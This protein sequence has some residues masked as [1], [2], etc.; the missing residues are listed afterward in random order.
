MSENKIVKIESTSLPVIEHLNQRVVTLAMVDEVHQRPSGTAGR[1]FRANRERFIESEDYFE[2]SE[3]ND[4]IRRYEWKTGQGGKIILLTESGYLM[5]VKSFTDD[6]AWQVQRAL[7]KSYFRV[8]SPAP[9]PELSELARAVQAL[10]KKITALAALP[11]VSSTTLAS[12]GFLPREWVARIS[13]SSGRLARAKYPADEKEQRRERQRLQMS[14]RRLC[15]P[16]GRGAS[17]A[18]CPASALPIVAGR[19]AE[20]DDETHRLE[21]RLLRSTASQLALMPTAN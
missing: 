7:V 21:A 13:G 20:W 9:V 8:A 16:V 5:L 4:E 15:H 10:D 1:N 19:I 11:V 14:L 17:W 3:G 18:A 2:A 6:L 12:G